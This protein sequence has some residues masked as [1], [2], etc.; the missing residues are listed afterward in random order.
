MS[1]FDELKRRNVFRAGIAY[2]VVAWLILQVADVILPNLGAP[3]WL[4]R[5]IL[6]LLVVGF[7]VV[8]VIAW[9][10]ELTTEGFKRETDVEHADAGTHTLGRQLDF[11][12]IAMLAVAVGYFAYDKFVLSAT[13]ADKSIAVLPFVN[14]SH[15]SEQEYF[16]DGLSE[17]LLNL[18][19]KVPALRVIARTSSFSYKGKEDVTIAQIASDLNV[20]HVLEGS[21]RKDAGDQLRVT[22][23]LIRADDQSQLWS[24]SYD[25]ELSDVFAIQ[26]EIAAAVVGE[27]KV[28]LL[29]DVPRAQQANLEAYPLYLK[30]RELSP[31]IDP[32]RAIGLYRQAI[33]I[34][35]D[36]AAAWSG[37]AEN[38]LYLAEKV[39]L[40]SIRKALTG[41]R[42][43][44]DAVLNT[45]QDSSFYVDEAFEEARC[46]ANRA[47][48]IDSEQAAA[49]ATLGRIAMV[50]D[51][52]LAVAAKHLE[53]ALD[54]EPANA[55]V[56][57][58]VA[59]LSAN[60]RRVDEAIAL[61]EYAV[62]RDPV[63]PS[64]QNNLALNYYYA[65]E[66]D[67]AISTYRTVI[68][69]S[70]NPVGVHSWI[71]LALVFDDKPEA[72]LAEIKLERHTDKEKDH[73]ERR[74][75]RLIAEAMT[76]HALGRAGESDESLEQLI[77]D[78]GEEWAFSV[79]YVLAYR[80]D[81]DRAFEWLG[82]AKENN[83]SGL[84]EIASE[85]AFDNLKSDPRW[86]P[87]LESIDK[88]PE[89]LAAIEFDVSVPN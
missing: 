85:P 49:F 19:V 29:G 43:R 41:S 23:Q 14:M 25:R 15:D 47:L 48:K 70:S 26:D 53:R 46:A 50:R 20:A 12:I 9:V 22:A 67:K 21:V 8:L 87:F 88:A 54:L 84:S 89:Q 73:N 11:V 56:I 34:D 58:Q 69:L 68:S 52:N 36:Y 27:L 42:C 66:W 74:A 31:E 17:E 77:D 65:G 18:L 55:Q 32:E 4:F 28:R 2:V 30:A 38:F 82:R 80:G 7:P 37:L 83:D 61:L 63:S 1:F 75:W 5:V 51:G 81:A 44:S 16:A 40:E 59:I 24:E 64:V 10:Y 72:G 60:L 45:D 6:L 57:R 86:L 35:S 3:E 39:R 71:G 13:T 78:Y 79:A 62:A 33:N 76:Y